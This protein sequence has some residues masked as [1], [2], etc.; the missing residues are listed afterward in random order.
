MAEKTYVGKGKST[1]KY[2]IVNF[3]VCLSDLPQAEINEY[4]GK[5]YIN[6]SIAPMKSADKYG[7][8]HTV[9]INDFKPEVKRDESSSNDTGAE[10][11]NLPF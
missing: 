8:T 4:N 10:E 2:D 1:G 3:S 6:L 5:K 11:T 9:W 7:K